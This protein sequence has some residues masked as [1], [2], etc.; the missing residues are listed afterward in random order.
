LTGWI[1]PLDGVQNFFED[2]W[3]WISKAAQ[4]AVGVVNTWI[5]DGLK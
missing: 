3:N 2:L 5:W 1:W 4:D